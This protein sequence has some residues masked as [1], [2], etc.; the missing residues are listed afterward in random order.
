M[1]F[2]QGDWDAWIT[3]DTPALKH[4]KPSDLSIIDIGMHEDQTAAFYHIQPSS[5]SRFLVAVC[6]DPFHQKISR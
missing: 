3:I 4:L 1:A 2:E 5:R 6:R